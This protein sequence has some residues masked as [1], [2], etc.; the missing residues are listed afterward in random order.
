MESR[1]LSHIEFRQSS[2]AEAILK[3]LQ[4]KVIT[5]LV[6]SDAC[7]IT[8]EQNAEVQDRRNG[9]PVEEVVDAEHVR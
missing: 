7:M 8:D 4:I 2:L 6:L 1:T 5:C 9:A 3:R